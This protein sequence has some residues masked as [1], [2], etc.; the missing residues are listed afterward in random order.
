MSSPATSD[1]EPQNRDKRPDA[2]PRKARAA[3]VEAAGDA[4]DAAQGGGAGE[5]AL[6]TTGGREEPPFF[7]CGVCLCVVFVCLYMCV[8]VCVFFFLWG[9]EGVLP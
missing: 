6:G 2:S 3:G 9:G 5:A 1:S 7:R 8:C 4:G